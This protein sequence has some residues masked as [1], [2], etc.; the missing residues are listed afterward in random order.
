MATFN[1]QRGETILVALDATV[2]DV[3]EVTSVEPK[4]VRIA[5]GG[6]DIPLEALPQDITIDVIDRAADGPI[7]AGWNLK[8][9]AADSATLLPGIYALDCKVDVGGDVIIP[10][11]I[12]LNILKAASV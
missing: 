12:K 9:S 2:G 6:A 5:S 8:I 4:L 11:F 3:S 1:F 7:P 10:D